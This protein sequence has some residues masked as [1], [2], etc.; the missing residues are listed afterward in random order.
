MFHCNVLF[1]SPK[2]TMLLA[3]LQ[4]WQPVNMRILS[5]IWWNTPDHTKNWIEMVR[6]LEHGALW[7]KW[8]ILIARPV[9]IITISAYRCMDMTT[10]SFGD[11]IYCPLC[12]HACCNFFFLRITKILADW[13]AS[14]SRLLSISK[15][16]AKLRQLLQEYVITCI[17]PSSGQ[18][19]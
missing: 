17:C 13:A 8:S 2:N 14:S 10:I 5:N 19:I 7:S 6:A 16:E 1:T 12:L 3:Y 18:V 11:A 15:V 4:R 9:A